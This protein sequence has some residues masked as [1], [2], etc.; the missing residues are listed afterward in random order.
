[1]QSLSPRAHNAP[2]PADLLPFP[3]QSLS[4]HLVLRC[5]TCG[6]DLA[7]LA[8]SALASNCAPLICR[9][10]LFVTTQ[11]KGMWRALREDRRSHFERFIKDYETVRRLEG[12]GS[13]VAHF[14]LALPNVDRTCRNS[15][16]WTIRARTYAYLQRTILSAISSKTS[17]LNILDLG[18]GNGWMSYRLARQGHRPVAVDLV[19][20]DFD[21]LGAGVHYQRVLP[22]MFPR[23]QAE[24]E[25]LPF[26]SRQFDCA[27]FNASFHYSEDYDRTLTEAIRC[28]RRGGLLV[29]ADSPSYSREESGRQMLAERHESFQRTFGFKSDSLASREFL[30]QEIL[31]ELEVRHDIQW[32]THRLWYGIQWACRPLI[33]RMKGRREPS[34]F[35]IYTAQVSR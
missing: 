12:R 16:Q 10:C 26:A 29:I 14:Y 13:D 22:V 19:T 2:A 17:L 31:R 1:M 25:N 11:E 33:A 5:T 32:T 18:A 15:W 23:F 34:Q 8:Y 21:G 4:P 20:N 28:L 35:R 3:K 24:F 6:G 30:T 7:E 9:Q 27:V